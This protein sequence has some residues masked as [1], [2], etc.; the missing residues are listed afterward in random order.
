MPLPTIEQIRLDHNHWQ[1]DKVERIQNLHELIMML[2]KSQ[3]K[4]LYRA[5]RAIT[6]ASLVIDE[7][8]DEL[9][10]DCKHLDLINFYGSNWFT[11]KHQ[12]LQSQWK[13]NTFGTLFK[14]PIDEVIF[15]YQR[16]AETIP[17][18]RKLWFS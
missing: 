1:K 14:Y 8:H 17:S 4:R 7:I 12:R 16:I 15:L 6:N 18:L 11:L 2:N 3:S 9:C 10:D 5:M 13:L